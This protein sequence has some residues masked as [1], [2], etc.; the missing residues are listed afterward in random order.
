MTVNTAVRQTDPFIGDDVTTTLPFAFKVFTDADLLVVRTD[1][2][3]VDET[4]TLNSDYTVTRNANQNTNPGGE[5]ELAD[6]LA[7]D[8]SVVITTDIAAT[9]GAS[10][11]NN[12]AFFATIVENA[13][14][15]LTILYQQLSARTAKAL[16][17]PVSDG[18]T[19]SQ[20]TLPGV[21]ERAGSYL[22]FDAGG[23]PVMASGTGA[24]SAL[25]TDLAA[26]TGASLV[27]AI[28]SGTG[29]V[30]RTVQAKLRET[31]SATDFGADKTGATNCLVAVTAAW[32]YCLANGADLYLP[33]GLYKITSENNFP[34]GRI[35]GSAPTSLLDCGNITIFGDGP[36]TI[37][38]TETS[39]GGDVLQ[40]N[41]A[42][43]LHI[44][45]LA[46]TATLT[47]SSGSGS[48]GISVTGGFDNISILDVW[49]DNCP[50]L[51]KTSF[52]DGGKGLSVQCDAATLEVGTL[53]A[54]I[55]VNGCAQ[56]FGCEID[57]DA[58]QA[59]KTAIDVDLIAEDCFTAV[60][61]GGATP[62]AAVS[63]GYQIGLKVRALAV[64]CQK[65]LNLGR[66]H[67]GDYDVRVVTTKT[68]AAR[69]LD[70]QG[71]A[72]YA[73]DAVVEAAI[74]TY[75]K[76]ATIRVS[77]NNGAC[78][79]KARIGGATPGSSGLSGATEHCDIYLDIAGTAATKDIEAVDSGGNTMSHCRLYC[80]TTTASALP[81]E[82]Y[83]A[84]N[85]NDLQPGAFNVGAFTGT[86]S[87]CTTSPTGVIEWSL[88][89]DVVTMTIP[90]IEGTSNATGASITGMPT[91]LYPSEAQGCVAFIT[92]NSTT[93]ASRLNV[94]TNGVIQIFA[95]PVSS[96]FTASGTKGVQSCV[97]TYRRS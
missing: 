66:M 41:G 7:S 37:L 39:G 38:Q 45:N 23:L 1:E 33:A 71:T 72:W 27:G 42:K 87:G 24:D 35:D 4:L 19:L 51:D 85:A 97:V 5:V 89:D 2:D 58:F 70:P 59:K 83:L 15:K 55:I 68:A 91:H 9:Q 90:V 69:R 46:V 73:A 63:A 40:L 25:R 43:N 50:G 22:A 12:S 88:N 54:R 44:R 17:F 84:V 13:L 49:V 96:T 74:V 75:A 21:A 36:A 78:D 16:R 31:V 10:I 64:N 95:T 30:S 34:F 86:L 65:G 28:Y 52:I 61:V 26:S 62:S 80:T 11:P 56:G 53:K 94:N 20:S 60:S 93:V 82:F 14:D 81:D 32:D 3:G 8:F 29:A 76:N 92:D 67:G 57:A 79:Y 6:P 48:N 77:G 18:I 47:G